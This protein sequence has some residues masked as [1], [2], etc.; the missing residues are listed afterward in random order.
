MAIE[1]V[2][3]E[4]VVFCQAMNRD[5]AHIYKIRYIS[6]TTRDDDGGLIATTYRSEYGGFFGEWRVFEE[7]EILDMDFPGVISFHGREWMWVRHGFEEFAEETKQDRV[8]ILT[9]RNTLDR[10]LAEN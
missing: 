6:I 7:F 2:A 8:H 9:I 5:A 3:D 10:W 1:R 4:R